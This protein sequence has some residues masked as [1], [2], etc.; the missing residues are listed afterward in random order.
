M[1]KFVLETFYALTAA[2]I[3]FTILELIHPGLV[4]AYFNL[5]YILL[6]WLI[7][8]II[9]LIIKDRDNDQERKV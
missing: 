8:V 6:F 4:L 5:D 7:N 3:I 9:L 1:K 2:L